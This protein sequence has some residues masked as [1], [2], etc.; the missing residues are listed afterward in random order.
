MAYKNK[1]DQAIAAR[2]HYLKNKDKMIARA[3]KYSVEISKP[4]AKKFIKDYLTNNPCVDC[5]ETDPIVLEFDHIRDKKM[6]IGDAVGKGCSIETIQKEINKCEVRCANCHRRITHK[7][8]IN[9]GESVGPP[10]V[11]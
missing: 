2:R 9:S 1:E 11:S 5:G 6:N 4:K 10:S 7:R 8:R 3:K